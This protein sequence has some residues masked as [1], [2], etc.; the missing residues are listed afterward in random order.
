MPFFSFGT[1]YQHDLKDVLK[2][3]DCENLISHPRRQ[4]KTRDSVVALSKFYVPLFALSTI[5]SLLLGTW[6]GS[7]YLR[8][9]AAVCIDR[10]SKYCMFVLVRAESFPFVINSIQ[11][12][13]FVTLKSS[14]TGSS[15]K[16]LSCMKISSVGMRVQRLMRHGHPWG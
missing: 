16:A 6:L 2:D 4:S 7:I 8:N 10:T 15:S 5:P 3:E 1:K 11:R 12:Q 14:M 9:P 13:C